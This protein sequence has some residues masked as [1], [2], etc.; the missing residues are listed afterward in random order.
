MT[1]LKSALMQAIAKIIALTL[2]LTVLFLIGVHLCIT[3]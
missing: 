2:A 1:L 3:K